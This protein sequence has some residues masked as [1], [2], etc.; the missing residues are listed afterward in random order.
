MLKQ[1]LFFGAAVAVLTC[2]AYSPAMALPEGLTI[3]VDVGRTQARGYCRNIT[4]CSNADTGPKIELGYSFNE[5]FGV[6]VG[7]TSFGTSFD[8]GDS[9]VSLSQDSRVVTVSAL[10]TLPINDWL[11]LYARGG[12]GWYK[13]D[14]S[15]VIQGLPARDDSG[16]TPYWGAGAK[17]TVSDR[18]ALRLEYQAFTDIARATGRNDDIQALFAGVVFRL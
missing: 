3:G 15:G 7:Y 14:N 9:S 8:S 18:L 2:G 17:F 16:T 11:G 12:L 10:G 1:K 4:N 13:T 5:N 6:E